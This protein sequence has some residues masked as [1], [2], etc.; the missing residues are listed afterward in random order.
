[1]PLV[2]RNV[3]GRPML[4]AGIRR[5]H[6]L[7]ELSTRIPLQWDDFCGLPPLPGRVGTGT[8][9]VTC[10]VWGAEMEYLTGVEVESF[11][12][13][14]EGMGRMRIPAQSYVVFTHEGPVSGLSA[15]WRWIWEEWLPASGV[16]P[17]DTPD[18]ETYGEGFDRDTGSGI[19]EIWFPV[20]AAG[21]LAGSP[22]EP[23]VGG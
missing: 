6:P 9:G 22:S 18:F 11:D 8:L 4:V 10:G 3:T 7:V 14:P 19:V 21:A 13:L 16:T 1:M 2:H 20:L 12:A 23:P 5:R 15:T 17:A